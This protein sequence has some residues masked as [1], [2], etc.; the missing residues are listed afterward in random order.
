MKVYL[1]YNIPESED[2]PSLNP[3][4]EFAMKKHMEKEKYKVMWQ[5]RSLENEINQEGGLIIITEK[6]K[7]H[8]KDFTSELTEKIH[9]LLI[10]DEE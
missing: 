3:L 4:A 2:M 8:T 7:I 1:E 9:Q 5:L 6:G 10:A